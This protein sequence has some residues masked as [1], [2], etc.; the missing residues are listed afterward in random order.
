MSVSDIDGSYVNLSA[1]INDLQSAEGM[2]KMMVDRAMEQDTFDERAAMD[3]MGL[4]NIQLRQRKHS[5]V[6][7]LLEKLSVKSEMDES[8]WL[9]KGVYTYHSTLLLHDALVDIAHNTDQRD[10]IV[11][12]YEAAIEGASA[13]MSAVSADLRVSLPLRLR[14]MLARLLWHVGTAEQ[15]QSA[16]K[17]WEEILHMQPDEDDVNY[18]NIMWTR[19]I[20]AQRLAPAIV[21]AAIETSDG[22][23]DIEA[24]G[25]YFERLQA[26]QTLDGS[27]V[28]VPAADVRVPLARML[29][30]L[31]QPEKAK[32]VIRDCIGIAV[33]L[34]EESSGQNMEACD[35]LVNAFLAIEDDANCIATFTLFDLK[36]Q[37]ITPDG[38]N[39]SPKP[40]I[41]GQQDDRA[42][43][44]TSEAE[45][46]NSAT[47]TQALDDIHQ[48]E[49]GAI[50]SHI[51]KRNTDEVSTSPELNSTPPEGLGSQPVNEGTADDPVIEM[52]SSK[53]SP[54]STN[55][56]EDCDVVFP[57]SPPAIKPSLSRL[58]TSMSSR[59]SSRGS[60]TS[61][62]SSLPQAYD[63]CSSVFCDS[64]WQYPCN[65]YACRDCY[66]IICPT[67]YEELRDG[68]LDKVGC[69]PSHTHLFIPPVEEQRWKSRPGDIVWVDGKDV[70]L[71]Q[72]LDSIKN[73]WGIEQKSLKARERLISAARHVMSVN[74]MQKTGRLAK[75]NSAS[76]Y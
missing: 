75:V 65:I 7:Q 33:H 28:H 16:L 60:G 59:S 63:R 13:T 45:A 40:G 34:L 56:S 24:V 25:G 8:N 76:S 37:P 69:A 62:Q 67:C 38:T 61:P 5:E 44:E 51:E 54:Q 35:R 68:T 41:A 4:V 15:R 30:L 1:G 10:R 74:R 70:P 48:A 58:D 39:T 55:V 73:E 57:L 71:Q 42:G 49:A 9:V 27:I 14:C 66:R 64:E 29:Y 36:P 21:C 23:L 32:E 53:D 26:L 43:S 17:M 72:W 46:G 19:R 3:I 47:Q 12:L 22:D 20:A 31:K 18:T 11:E 6:V 52:Q 50:T 2:S